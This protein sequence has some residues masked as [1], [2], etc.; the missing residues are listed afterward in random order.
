ME[1]H[2]DASF[3]API[4]EDA[5]VAL[6]PVAIKEATALRFQI[7]NDISCVMSQAS[8][9]DLQGPFA[10]TAAAGFALCETAIRSRR[11]LSRTPPIGSGFFTNKHATANTHEAR[12]FSVPSQIVKRAPAYGVG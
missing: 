4:F 3:G 12:P 10:V 7:R 8:R 6:A 2:D 9:S 11:Q 5:L 1:A